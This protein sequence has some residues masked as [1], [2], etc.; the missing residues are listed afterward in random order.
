[1]MSEEFE[2][3]LVEPLSPD[4][5]TDIRYLSEEIDLSSIFQSSP[6]SQIHSFLIEKVVDAHNILGRAL[7]K[8]KKLQLKCW[9]G[10]TEQ[11]SLL[12]ENELNSS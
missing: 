8:Y 9:P 11:L 4:E 10:C 2:K 12:D 6:V 7:T 1:M 3:Y 5:S